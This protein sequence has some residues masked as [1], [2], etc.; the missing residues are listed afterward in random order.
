VR[1]TTLSLEVAVV[2]GEWDKVVR[3]RSD[4]RVLLHKQ[5]VFMHLGVVEN[6]EVVVWVLDT[7]SHHSHDGLPCG[8]PGS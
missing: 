4:G 8:F 6:R 3:S 5:K 2:T 7:R 1:E